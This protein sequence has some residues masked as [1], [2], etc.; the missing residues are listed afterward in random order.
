MGAA[1]DVH[2]RHGPGVQ[3]GIVHTGGEGTGGGVEVLDLL[4]LAAGSVQPL[5]QGDGVV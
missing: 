1:W 2:R 4:W 5:G 3:A